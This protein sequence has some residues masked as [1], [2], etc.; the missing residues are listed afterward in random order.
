MKE[1]RVVSRAGSSSEN[2]AFYFNLNLIKFSFNLRK[3][4]STQLQ[5]RKY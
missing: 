3:T 2:N 1:E 4:L 5:K